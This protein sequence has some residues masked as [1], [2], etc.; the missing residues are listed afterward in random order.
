MGKVQL[1]S[2]NLHGHDDDRRFAINVEL[3]TCLEMATDVVSANHNPSRQKSK[4]E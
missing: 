3:L 1:R 4:Q 2:E